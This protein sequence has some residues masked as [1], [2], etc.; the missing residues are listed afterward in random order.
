MPVRLTSLAF[1]LLLAVGF[2]LAGCSTTAP[3]GDVNHAPVAD[4]GS[5]RTVTVGHL[6]PLDGRG[7][8]DPDSD[9]LAYLWSF[10]SRPAGSAA[11]I[12]PDT[13]VTTSFTP[14]VIGEYRVHLAIFDGRDGDG[15]DVTITAVPATDRVR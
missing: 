13:T 1:P 8:Y 10:T 6:A 11:V 4:A 3:A 15:D 5:D 12:S 9:P 14:D 2:A 7:S